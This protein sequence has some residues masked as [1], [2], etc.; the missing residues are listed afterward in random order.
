MRGAAMN[1]DS[2]AENKSGGEKIGAVTNTLL[3]I[4]VENLIKKKF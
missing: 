4:F 1:H 2:E 3:F